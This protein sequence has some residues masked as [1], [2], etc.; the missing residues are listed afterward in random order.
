M[1]RITYKY[2]VLFF[3]SLSLFSYVELKAQ[4]KTKQPIHS[5]ELFDLKTDT[6]EINNVYNN[7]KYEKVQQML[8]DELVRMRK[9]IRSTEGD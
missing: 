4:E 1:K 7:K 2:A 9:D 8:T 6:M 3:A 5:W